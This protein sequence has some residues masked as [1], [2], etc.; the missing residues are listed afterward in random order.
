M[1]GVVTRLVRLERSGY[2]PLVV[3]VKTADLREL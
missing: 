1:A 2:L 3:V